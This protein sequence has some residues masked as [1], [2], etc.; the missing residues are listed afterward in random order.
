MYA[1]NFVEHTEPELK[2]EDEAKVSSSTE[3]LKVEIEALMT[4]LVHTYFRN[5][6][7]PE[8]P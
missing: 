3:V 8:N 7:P 5:S 1:N 4:R 6:K 2:K